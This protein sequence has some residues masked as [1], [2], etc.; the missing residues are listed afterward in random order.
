MNIPI[1]NK[2]LSNDK[3]LLLVG[4]SPNVKDKEL[5]NLINTDNFNIFRFNKQVVLGYEKYI[6]SETTYRVVNGFTWVNNNNLI[7]EDNIIIAEPYNSPFYNKIFNTK[8]VNNFKSISRITDYTKNYTDIF[9]TSGFMTISFLLQFYDYI[10]IY[11]FSY[12]GTHFYDNSKGAP[13]HKYC[14]EKKIIQNLIRHKKI[15][16]L[17]EKI[18]LPLSLIKPKLITNISNLTTIVLCTDHRF[19]N[20]K[21]NYIHFNREDINLPKGKTIYVKV[22]INDKYVYMIIWGYPNHSFNINTDYNNTNFDLDYDLRG[23]SHG[24]DLL[25]NYKFQ[26]A[27]KL[28]II[29]I[30]P[31][32]NILSLKHKHGNK[33][34]AKF[35]HFNLNDIKSIL[36]NPDSKT[37]YLKVIHPIHKI[38]KEIIIWTNNNGGCH[39]DSHGRF[40]H[41]AKPGD[42]FKCNHLIVTEILD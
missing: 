25:E 1:L 3:N 22:K 4:N 27:N 31:S 16:Y 36:K 32:I 5:G 2:K 19:N 8:I 6:G 38:Q 42:F 18:K 33:E 28:E 11:G 14:V 26:V 24:K 10:Y 41:N 23:N 13:H 12:E 30:L 34:Y 37:I 9:P 40:K 29:N 7:E 20:D 21:F 15:I 17:D 35:F 39:G